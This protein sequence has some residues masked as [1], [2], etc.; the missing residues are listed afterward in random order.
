MFLSIDPISHPI[1]PSSR[2]VQH[3]HAPLEECAGGPDD[4]AFRR[5]VRHLLWRLARRQWRLML[6]HAPALARH[7]GRRLHAP[8]ARTPVR[9]H[10]SHRQDVCQR[11]AVLE[12][13]NTSVNVVTSWK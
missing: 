2:Q 10:W 11:L 8:R 13:R 4:F 3:L 7:G 9:V 1:V 5:E 12:T 6:R